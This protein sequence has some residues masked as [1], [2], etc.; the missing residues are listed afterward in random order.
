MAKKKKAIE[1]QKA[2]LRG[3]GGGGGDTPT[4]C[5]S[6]VVHDPD[7]ELGM[8]V[9][10]GSVDGVWLDGV[11]ISGGGG[12]DIQ[13]VNITIINNNADEAVQLQ[14]SVILGDGLGSNSQWVYGGETGTVKVVVAAGYGTWAN[15]VGDL[16]SYTLSGDIE[17]MENWSVSIT[18]DGTITVE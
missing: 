18:G 17:D 8:K 2:P 6:Y 5:N 11:D 14:E 9:T 16:T 13:S 4:N 10:D 3:G 1:E 12:G 7:H 15:I